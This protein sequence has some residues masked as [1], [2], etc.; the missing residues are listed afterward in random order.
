MLIPKIAFLV[1]VATTSVRAQALPLDHAQWPPEVFASAY[2]LISTQPE[3]QA[4]D[5]LTGPARSEFLN[6]FW[7]RR[8]PTPSTPEN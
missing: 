4:I 2:R 8:D 6:R 1:L 7:M 3:Q 5:T